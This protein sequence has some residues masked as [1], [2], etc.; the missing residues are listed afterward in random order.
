MHFLVKV[1]EGIAPPP[2]SQ[3]WRGSC[4]L[5]PPPMFLG[6]WSMPHGNPPFPGL[7]GPFFGA[8]CELSK[9]G[10]SIAIWCG[11]AS[12]GLR[13]QDYKIRIAFLF[14]GLQLDL[15]SIQKRGFDCGLDCIML[16]ILQSNP[17]LQSSPGTININLHASHFRERSRLRMM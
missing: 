10:H 3:S 5:C 14:G 17:D 1:N 15:K 11:Q 4:P 6:L 8:F 2:R 16:P 12:S 13:L 7:I 9:N